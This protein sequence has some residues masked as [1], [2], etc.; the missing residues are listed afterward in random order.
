MWLARAV[1]I[2]G[3]GVV[4]V[5]SVKT[6]PAVRAVDVVPVLTS[7][8]FAAAPGRT[9]THSIA[10][11]AS[12]A[13]TLTAVRVTFTTTVD[14]D[15]VTASTS[16]GS[17]PIVT[18]LTVVCELGTVDFPG[19][20]TAPTVTVTGTVR[21]G[22][23][24]GALVQNLVN[25][26]TGTPDGDPSNNVASN[27]YLAGGAGATPTRVAASGPTRSASPA[28]RA[29][30]RVGVA[31]VVALLGLGALVAAASVLLW[32]RRRQS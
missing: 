9:V 3:V 4:L 27:A 5:G 2:I 20:G 26:T 31:P 22:T 13:G 30:S 8:P 1:S 11:Q 21:P 29:A 14:L 23:S 32:W 25:V 19:A 7:T 10:L 18:A 12:G 28:T 16:S 15:G 17:C 6:D 24:P